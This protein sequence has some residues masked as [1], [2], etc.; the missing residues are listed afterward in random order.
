MDRHGRWMITVEVM[1]PKVQVY[2]VASVCALS[3]KPR[4]DVYI[5]IIAV[6]LWSSPWDIG[7]G[8]STYS[9]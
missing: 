7:L 2:T 9:L 8:L 3:V 6:P 4:D 1:S 5:D